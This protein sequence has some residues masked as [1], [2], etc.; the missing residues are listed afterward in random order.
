[1]PENSDVFDYVIVGAGTAGSNV[2][3]TKFGS[4]DKEPHSHFYTVKLR[5][6]FKGY[7]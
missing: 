5:V 1:M 2:A 6:I 7:H 3:P 4:L